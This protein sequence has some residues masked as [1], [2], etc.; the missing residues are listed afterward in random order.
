[1]SQETHWVEDGSEKVADQ[2]HAL[3]ET[4][5]LYDASSRSR[6]CLLGNDRASFLHGQVTQE[7]QKLDS[8]EGIYAALADLKGRFVSDL[9]VY[10]LPDEILLDFEPNHFDKVRERLETYIVSEDV[11]LVDPS[12]HYTMLSL[13]GP[14]SEKGLS[15]CFDLPA[16]PTRPGQLVS[17]THSEIE[18]EIYVSCRPRCPGHGFDLFVPRPHHQHVWESLLQATESIQGMVV[19]EVAMEM[20]RIEAGIPR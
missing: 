20:V 19:G 18:G 11:C 12:E 1:M 2:W 14:L 10:C 13:Q 9:N 17:F 5:G 8:G 3:H 6:L 4:C 16:P 7:I 15:H